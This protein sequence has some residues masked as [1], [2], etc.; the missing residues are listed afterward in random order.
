MVK[1]IRV[2]EKLCIEMRGKIQKGDECKTEI[3]K[4][5][6]EKRSKTSEPKFLGFLVRENGKSTMLYFKRRA[7]AFITDL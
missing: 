4:K 5:K 6:K 1:T 3:D 2:A 7:V